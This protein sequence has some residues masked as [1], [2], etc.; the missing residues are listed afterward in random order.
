MATGVSCQKKSRKQIAM[1][2]PR[3]DDCQNIKILYWGSR[4]EKFG[5]RLCS[6]FPYHEHYACG[7][8]RA[9]KGVVGGAKGPRKLRGGEGLLPCGKVN[10]PILNMLDGIQRRGCSRESRR[11]QA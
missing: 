4:A 7:E 11:C 8:R 5:E 10:R 1:A 6:P 3:P 9:D 2:K